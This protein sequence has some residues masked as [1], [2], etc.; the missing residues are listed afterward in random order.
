[1]TQTILIIV[2][3]TLGAAAAYG[4]IW[5][6][7]VGISRD[8]RLSDQQVRQLRLGPPRLAARPSVRRASRRCLA[9]CPS[10][11]PTRSLLVTLAG[12]ARV[13]VLVDG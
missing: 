6:L 7:A 8:R 3:A 1:M 10:A 9:G 4:L 13:V 5:L 12:E 2:N 11:A